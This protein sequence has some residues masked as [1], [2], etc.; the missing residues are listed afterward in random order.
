MCRFLLF[1]LNLM[2]CLGPFQENNGKRN[3]T[4]EHRIRVCVCVTLKDK[5]NA[6]LEPE[7]ATDGTQRTCIKPLS[8]KLS[9][10]NAP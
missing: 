5:K 1:R 2:V 8:S 6:R 9:D 10:L 7:P 3:A 4:A